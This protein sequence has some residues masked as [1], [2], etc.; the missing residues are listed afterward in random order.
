MLRAA[1]STF[2]PSRRTPKTTSNEIAVALRSSR[3]RTTV[4]SR[5]SRTMF[6]SLSE[7]RHHASQ[8]V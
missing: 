4:P 5:T 1:N 6:S 3:T 8:S 2:W 7:R